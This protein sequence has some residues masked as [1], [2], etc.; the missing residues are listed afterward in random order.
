MVVE[1]DAVEI[2]TDVLADYSKETVAD[3]TVADEPV[4]VNNE[5]ASDEPSEPNDATDAPKANDPSEGDQKSVIPFD[6]SNMT[7]EQYLET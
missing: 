4:V 3:D 7:Y 2:S 6:I 5:L 1:G